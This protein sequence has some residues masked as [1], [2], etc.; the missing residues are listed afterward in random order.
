[1]LEGNRTGKGGKAGK[2]FFQTQAS[3]RNTLGGGEYARQSSADL[4]F[5][6]I[7]TFFYSSMLER[8]STYSLI[9][10]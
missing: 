8:S 5:V 6:N 7:S 9:A 10:D 3:Q 2:E 1:M 4:S